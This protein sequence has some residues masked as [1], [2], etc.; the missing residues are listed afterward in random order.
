M[1]ATLNCYRNLSNFLENLNYQT[2][3]DFELVICDGGSTDGTVELLAH[4][5]VVNYY[6]IHKTGIYEALNMLIGR[7]SGDWVLVLGSD[8]SLHDFNTI[9]NITIELQK[10]EG[11]I[12]LAYGDILIRNSNT[13]IIKKYPNINLFQQQYG[14]FPPFHH[15]SLLIRKSMLKDV[16]GFSIK[17]KVHADYALFCEVLK[18]SHAKK[19]NLVISNF[20]EGG[21]SGSVSKVFISIG[22]LIRIRK[23]YGENPFYGHWKFRF[24]IHLLHMSLKLILPTRFLNSIKTVYR[25]KLS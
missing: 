11:Q 20:S 3:R 24:A 8:D 13:S 12:G 5:K 15:Q 7:I 4:S 16:G 2:C 21:T 23:L 17:F 25:S 18:R 14:K 10:L 19:I 6:V 22:E 9:R 1:M